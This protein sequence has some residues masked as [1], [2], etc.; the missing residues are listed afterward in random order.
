[1]GD[2]EILHFIALR[3]EMEIEFAQKKRKKINAFLILETFFQL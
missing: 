1:L 2:G 3:G